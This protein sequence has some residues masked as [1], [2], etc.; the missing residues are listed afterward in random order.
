[1]I[2]AIWTLDWRVIRVG[3]IVAHWAHSAEAFALFRVA[4]G[5]ARNYRGAIGA[6]TSGWALDGLRVVLRGI[7][8]LANRTDGVGS[9]SVADSAIFALLARRGVLHGVKAR[10]TGLW[11]RIWC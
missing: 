7:T 2:V 3:A 10:G 1:M 6:F 8:G 5:I 9:I 4:A 11:Q